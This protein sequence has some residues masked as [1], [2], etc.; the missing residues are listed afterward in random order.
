[1]A[2]KSEIN[3][4]TIDSNGYKTH[5]KVIEGTTGEELVKLTT[6]QLELTQW[7][8]GHAFKPDTFGYSNG[9]AS[10][11][12]AQG[13]SGRAAAPAKQQSRGGGRSGGGGQ[14]RDPDGPLTDNQRKA[15][16]AI[17]KNLGMDNEGLEDW[18]GHMSPNDLTKAEASQ[19]I[20]DLKKLE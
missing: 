7:L 4:F 8:S 19:V 10:R 18:L 20:D 12:A 11:Q 6:R 17:S 16:Y 14:M 15:I 13:A 9:S 3:V 5:W 2:D 1:M